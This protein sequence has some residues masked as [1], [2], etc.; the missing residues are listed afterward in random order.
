[1]NQ[2]TNTQECMENCKE[3]SEMCYRTA[4]NQCLTMGGQHVEAE[5]FKL[6][7]EC[8][9]ICETS[10]CLQVSN[11]RF[12]RQLCGVCAQVCEACAESCEQV[13]DMDACVDMC[14]RC[15][16]SCRAMAA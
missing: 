16:E 14:R 11:S 1:M 2:E 9:K 7:L 5:H 15:A 6:M 10:A 3:C 12:S 13:G 8:A 4:L